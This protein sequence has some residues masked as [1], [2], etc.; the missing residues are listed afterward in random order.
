MQGRRGVMRSAAGIAALLA[1]G[2]ARAALPD[3]K[4]GVLTDFSG[5]YSDA[6]GAGSLLATRMAIEDAL[7]TECQDMA[8]EAV[9]ADHQNKPDIA[10]AIA[11]D[12]V[13]NAGVDALVD[14]SNAA[15]QLAIAPFM[16][17]R[18]RIALFAGGAARLTGDS[19]QPAH[20]V[21]W[22]WDTYVQVN[23][24]AERLTRPSTTW[25]LV[26]ADYAFGHQF[27]KDA[28]ALVT[29]AGGR[30]LGSARH[31]FPSTD[32]SAH[33]LQAQAPSADIVALA[34]AGRTR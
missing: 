12:W 5:V 30:V 6:T 24:V 1:A 29:A 33:L 23:G 20:I 26:T 4:L 21:Q 10:L 31:P 17:E 14:M 8:I 18:H 13:G 22:I 25:Y 7:A 11:R 3:V 9:S 2:S 27:E 16:V 15:I 32:L 28:Q 34:N 19:C